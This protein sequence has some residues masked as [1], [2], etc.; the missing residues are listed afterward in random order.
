MPE[1]APALSPT[2][3]RRTMP[4]PTPTLAPAPIKPTE[5]LTVRPHSLSAPPK[6][7]IAGVHSAHGVPAAA[8]AL[9]T[10]DRPLR[11]TSTPSN[12]SASLPR[13]QWSSSSPQTEHHI[14]GGAGLTSP[15]ITRPPAHVD[16]AARWATLRFLAPTTPLTSSEAPRAFLLNSTAMSRPKHV[17]PTSPA[18]CAHASPTPAT[19]TGDSPLDVTAR[20]PRTSSDP[21]PDLSYRR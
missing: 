7:K 12:P 21:P 3:S 19:T 10:V 4:D 6:R 15:D 20:S 5:A 13:A 17:S 16:W 8:R 18:A 14:A 2:R 1:H 9:T 11:P